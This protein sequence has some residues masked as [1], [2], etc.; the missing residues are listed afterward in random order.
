MPA[1]FIAF[2]SSFKSDFGSTSYMNNQFSSNS[3]LFRDKTRAWSFNALISALFFLRLK[4]IQVKILNK[5]LFSW[6]AKAAEIPEMSKSY[7]SE[8]KMA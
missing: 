3:S 8:K 1:S 7:F 4:Y 6:I 2:H 5:Q